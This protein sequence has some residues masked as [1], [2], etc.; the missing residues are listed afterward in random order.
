LNYPDDFNVPTFA[1]GKSIA[2]SRAMGI[3]IMSGF[4]IIVFLCGLLIWTIRSARVEPYIFMT[5]GI[6]D[7]WQI[8]RPGGG[9]PEVQ[10]TTPQVVQESLVW[11]FVQDWFLISNDTNVNAQ[12]W[13]NSCRRAD[14]GTADGTTPC[15]IFCDTSDDLFRRF[16]EDI[17]PQYKDLASANKYWTPIVK[18]IRTSPVGRIADV[19]G[20]WRVQMSVATN[21]DGNITIMAYA[22]VAQDKKSHPKN[23]GYYIADFN[24][25]RIK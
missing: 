7:E 4:L 8:V 23:M 24:A 2:I 13:D 15:R 17:L 22:K 9:H 1:A 16:S 12:N 5:G 14:C 19:G 10:M 6:N 25:Y 3:G 18:S 20:T 21:G 11:K